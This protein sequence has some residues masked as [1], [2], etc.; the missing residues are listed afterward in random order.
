MN[1]KPPRLGEPLVDDVI[2]YR[3]FPVKGYRERGAKDKP[4]KVRA[5]AFQ[6]PQD[7]EDGISLGLTPE[8]AISG[9]ESNHGYCSVSVAKIH[10]L[11]Y[12]LRVC[13]DLDEPGHLLL[14]NVPPINGTD[15]ER[16]LGTEIAGALARISVVVTCDPY[17]PKRGDDLPPALAGLP[18][19]SDT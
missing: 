15:E 10:S 19:S 12:G 8:A 18:G 13:P 14:R 7:H 11:K 4:H 6:R 17:P 2:V 1:T 16:E 5:K 3:A 9:L